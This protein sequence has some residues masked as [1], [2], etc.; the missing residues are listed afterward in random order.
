MVTINLGDPNVVENFKALNELRKTGMFT[1]DQLQKM[2]DKQV[3]ADR[4][5]DEKE[6]Q[7]KTNSRLVGFTS[8]KDDTSRLEKFLNHFAPTEL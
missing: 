2:Y 3:E 4:E 1:D 8:F 7:S 6:M 5:R